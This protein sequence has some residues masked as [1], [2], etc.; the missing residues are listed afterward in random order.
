MNKAI[1]ASAALLLASHTVRLQAQ[2]VAPLD[3]LLE[4]NQVIDVSSAVRGVLAAVDVD[5]GDLVE[6]DQIV[7]RLD[8][9]VEEAAMALAHARARANAEVR[10]DQ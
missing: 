2:T 3:C 8:S 7:A 10:A 6:Q 1:L 5:R 4:P 9:S